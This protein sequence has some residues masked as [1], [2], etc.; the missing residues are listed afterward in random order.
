MT[1]MPVDSPSHPEYSRT[2]HRVHLGVGL[3]FSATLF[4]LGY[5]CIDFSLPPSLSLSDT[6]VYTLR[7]SLPMAVVV[8]WAIHNVGQSRKNCAAIRPLSGNEH[9]NQLQKNF[10]SNSL[11][12]FLVAFVSIVVLSTYL[13]DVEQFKMIPVFSI[14]FVLARIIFCIGYAIHEDYRGV[15]MVMTYFP[16]LFVVAVD[17]YFIFSKGFV[18]TVGDKTTTLSTSFAKLWMATEKEL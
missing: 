3:G 2:L 5:W 7:W 13:E 6:L 12:Q 1:S 11:E 9:L 17:V 18:L 8:M 15:G 4:L 10:L 16:T 14:N